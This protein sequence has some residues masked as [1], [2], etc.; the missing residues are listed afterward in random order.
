MRNAVS[1]GRLSKVF[2]PQSIGSDGSEVTS[3]YAETV[4]LRDFIDLS[5]TPVR[6]VIVVSDPYHMRRARWTDEKVLGDRHRCTN[7]ACP[8]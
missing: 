1:C 6:S 3:T 8:F 7:G 4:R 2:Q 5:A